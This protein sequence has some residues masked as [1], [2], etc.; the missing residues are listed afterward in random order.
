[1]K[2]E[3]RPPFKLDKEA[4]ENLKRASLFALVFLAGV[5]VVAVALSYLLYFLAY[6]PEPYEGGL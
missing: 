3:I 1:M 5:S 2:I 4:W 6:L